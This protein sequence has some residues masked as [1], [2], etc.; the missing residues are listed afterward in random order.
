M[1]E[2]PSQALIY[3]TDL[4][5]ETDLE[6]VDYPILWICNSDHPEANIG[7]TVYVN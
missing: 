6:E 2:H 4:Y 5:G 1:K 7:E 3:F